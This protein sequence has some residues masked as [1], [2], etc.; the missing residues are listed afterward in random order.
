[1]FSTFVF[2]AMNQDIWRTDNPRES[3]HLKN[4]TFVFG[5]FPGYDSAIYSIFVSICCIVWRKGHIK[6]VIEQKTPGG[7]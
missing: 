2:N 7:L 4:R 5:F 1:M 6:G 3:E